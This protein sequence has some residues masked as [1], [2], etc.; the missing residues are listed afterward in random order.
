VESI[1]CLPVLSDCCLMFVD[2]LGSGSEV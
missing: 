2:A 1:L